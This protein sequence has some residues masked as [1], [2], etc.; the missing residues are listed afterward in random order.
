MRS[1]WVAVSFAALL[2]CGGPDVEEPTPFAL[3]R[4]GGAGEKA[5]Y[6]AFSTQGDAF[7]L[8]VSTTTNTFYVWR[9]GQVVPIGHV[10]N[11][12][13][14]VLL[15]GGSAA[16]V[17]SD[18][19]YV[20][21]VGSAHA[22]MLSLQRGGATVWRRV[23][24]S[25]SDESPRVNVIGGLAFVPSA[26]GVFVLDVA[27]GR[28]IREFTEATLKF[29]AVDL[30]GGL[31]AAF[32]ART[33]VMRSDTGE[34][35]CDAAPL[36]LKPLSWSLPPGLVVSV[37]KEVNQQTVSR[38]SADCTVTPVVQGAYPTPVDGG[39][40]LT[41]DRDLPSALPLPSIVEGNPARQQLVVF[42]ATGLAT[43]AIALPAGTVIAVPTRNLSRVFTLG[44]KNDTTVLD[45]AT[46]ARVGPN[47]QAGFFSH[48][49]DDRQF[50]F[51][52]S[53][54]NLTSLDVATG[55]TARAK[56]GK[57][58][59]I[60]DGT[61]VVSGVGEYQRLAFG[62]LKVVDTVRIP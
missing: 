37:T 22:H 13:S 35:V 17:V 4:P 15:E 31:L 8:G 53:G 6:G 18:F 5:I 30:G 58:A 34:A 24:G 59:G 12:A 25:E 21:S 43:R 7:S 52:S 2:A 44:A 41:V 14:S 40:S 9:S 60:F 61:V 39:F 55:A 46:G 19:A 10:A 50:L 28:L 27:T 20:P 1:S 56:V 45:V 33:F 51:F 57:V 42:D 29:A 11:A 16:L 3:P 54:A 32:G 49:S 48:A 36:E 23:V 38:L 47:A 26:H 62:T